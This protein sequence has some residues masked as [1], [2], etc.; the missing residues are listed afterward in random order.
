MGW[1]FRTAFSTPGAETGFAAAT[2]C[3]PNCG[4]AAIAGVAASNAK[5]RKN[6]VPVI[7]PR[8]VGLTGR[9]AFKRLSQ[10]TT[11]SRAGCIRHTG[12]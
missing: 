1:L 6:F 2:I 12:H 9:R 4:P 3:P 5:A 8:M 7:T 10:L 11:A